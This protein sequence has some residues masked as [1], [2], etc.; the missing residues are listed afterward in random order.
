MTSTVNIHEAK[1]HL[2]R[3]LERV[4]NGE[5][6]TIAKAGEPIAEL[7]AV[8]RVDVRFGG[9]RSEIEYDDHEFV[10]ADAEILGMYDEDLAR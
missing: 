2:S 6:I 5:V 7:R 10:A 1:T 3:L 9:M 4:R 8:S